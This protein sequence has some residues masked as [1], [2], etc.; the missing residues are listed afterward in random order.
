MDGQIIVR[1]NL[2]LVWFYFQGICLLAYLSQKLSQ[3]M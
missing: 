2:I 3:I 1:F